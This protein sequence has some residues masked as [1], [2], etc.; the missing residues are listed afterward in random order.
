MIEQR[1]FKIVLIT[2]MLGTAPMNPHIYDDYVAS[3]RP[4]DVVA[5]AETEEES[6]YVE[7]MDEKG[8]T[9]FRKDE[10]GLFI[11]DYM[12]KGFLKNAGNVLKDNIGIKALR[13]KIEDVVFISPRIIYLDKEKAD[14]ILERPLMANTPQGKRVA[15]ARSE[16]VNSGTKISFSISMF[17]HKEVTWSVIDT[18]MEYG[19]YLGLG[20]FRN[21]GYG[22]FI[23]EYDL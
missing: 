9:G 21:G 18:L 2:E 8:L 4:V 1:G 23:R 13:S 10:N 20:Q 16:Y 17:A 22:R 5:T 19:Q 6:K 7:N 3:K 12:V 14:G 11:Y 15:L